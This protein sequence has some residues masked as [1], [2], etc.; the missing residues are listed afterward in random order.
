M[1]QETGYNPRAILRAY[2]GADREGKKALTEGRMDTVGTLVPDF[3]QNFAIAFYFDKKSETK[4]REFAGRVGAAIEARGGR[5]TLI[6]SAIMPIHMTIQNG[7]FWTDDREEQNRRHRA[8]YEHTFDDAK[9]DRLKGTNLELK[10]LLLRPDSILLA[11]E[12]IP[13]AVKDFREALQRNAATYGAKDPVDPSKPLAARENFLH[14]TLARFNEMPL[15]PETIRAMRRELRKI[16]YTLSR[17]PLRVRVDAMD[18]KNTLAP[19][20]QRPQ[21]GDYAL[22]SI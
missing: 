16:R 5:A 11:V 19:G 12:D 7:R 2:A 9:A 15:E 10:Y 4:I 14:I 21:S 18:Y 20:Y 13:L 22:A 1:A 8:I 17:E 3:E 6:G